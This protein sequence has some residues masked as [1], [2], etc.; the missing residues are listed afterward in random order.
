M[1]NLSHI[2]SLFA[3]SN[4]RKKIRIKNGG[5]NVGCKWNYNK[6][7]RKE[8]RKLLERLMDYEDEIEHTN[9]NIIKPMLEKGINYKFISKVTKGQLKKYKNKIFLKINRRLF[10]PKIVFFF[11]LVYAI[12]LLKIG[13]R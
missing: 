10:F 1:R 5:H 2:F 7:R 13:S 8:R 4:K 6:K 11:F 3:T 12:L 9:L